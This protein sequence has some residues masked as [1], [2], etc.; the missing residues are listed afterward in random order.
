MKSTVSVPSWK[1]R[2]GTEGG[3]K[4]IDPQIFL[5]Q[6]VWL[7]KVDGPPPKVAKRVSGLEE[8]LGKTQRSLKNPNTFSFHNVD[9]V[10]SPLKP[11][12]RNLWFLII[13]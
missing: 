4:V 5:E 11:H 7:P 2:S 10:T 8:A 12:A 9:G 6:T 1:Q 3:P 13:R